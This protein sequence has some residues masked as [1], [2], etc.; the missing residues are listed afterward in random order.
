MTKI[1]KYLLIAYVIMIIGHV[2]LYLMKEES[3]T[4]F[5]GGV[6]AMICLIISIIVSKKKEE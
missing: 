3:L 6:V 5:I 1:R 2:V 4:S